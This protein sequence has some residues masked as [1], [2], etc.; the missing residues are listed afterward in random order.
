MFVWWSQVW[1]QIAVKLRQG[2]KGSPK[3]CWN[4]VENKW[5]NMTKKYRDCIDMNRRNGTNHRCRFQDE[6]AAVYSYNPDGDQKAAGEGF[7][8]PEAGQNGNTVEGNIFLSGYAGPVNAGMTNNLFLPTKREK[9]STDDDIV[10]G[11][12]GHDAGMFLVKKKK[13]LKLGPQIGQTAPKPILP[14]PSPTQ[15][16]LVQNNSDNEIVSLL[17]QLREDRIGHERTRMDRL[18]A[19]HREKM[20]MFGKFLDILKQSKQSWMMRRTLW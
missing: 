9:P 19:M 3:F 6:I 10:G 16:N 17:Q 13:Y 12:D 18:E 14:Q 8:S 20:N 7:L 4:H 5:K 11:G 2:R 1:E 15:L